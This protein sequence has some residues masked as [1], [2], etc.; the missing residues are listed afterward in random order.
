[1]LG[2]LVSHSYLKKLSQR[3]SDTLAVSEQKASV[4]LLGFTIG[5]FILMFVFTNLIISL[6]RFFC[7]CV[8]SIACAIN[9]LVH[10]LVAN[11]S[12]DEYTPG[13][14]FVGLTWGVQDAILAG[15]FE[16]DVINPITEG[17]EEG[18][19]SF[20]ICRILGVLIIGFVGMGMKNAKPIAMLII[21]IIVC[22]A[23]IGLSFLN[24]TRDGGKREEKLLVE[25]N[26]DSSKSSEPQL[27]NPTLSPIE[28]AVVENAGIEAPAGPAE[29]P[30]APGAD[31][32]SLDT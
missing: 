10:S 32:E 18:I 13:W 9:L 19:D 23:S 21:M 28:S 27:G 24:M 5:K 8:I 4:A 2:Y 7:F 17:V 31:E 29:E 22:L 25:I 30:P 16:V 26:E 3:D 20:M 12:S 14:F 15:K 6:P 1:M 11:I